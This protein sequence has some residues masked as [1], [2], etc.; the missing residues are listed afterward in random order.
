MNRQ[1]I[2]INGKQVFDS[3][4]EDIQSIEFFGCN[5]QT[6]VGINKG[7]ISVSSNGN[8]LLVNGQSI[9]LGSEPVLKIEV[10]GNVQKLSAGAAD[11]SITGDAGSVDTVSG[12]VSIK[13]NV[14]SYVKTVS[15]DVR[16]SAI[17]GSVE[18]VSGD[19]YR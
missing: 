13:G 7:S 18:T 19:I 9:E 5:I 12:D 10:F 15:G 11:V 2:Y 8:Q 14:A 1:G 17:T 4:G 3:Q 6:V 16:C